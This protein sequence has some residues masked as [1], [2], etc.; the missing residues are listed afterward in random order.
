M[1]RKQFGT[2]NGTGVADGANSVLSGAGARGTRGDLTTAEEEALQVSHG[3]SLSATCWAADPIG[4]CA[5]PHIWRVLAF[6][7][8]SAPD[9]DLC[10]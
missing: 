2:A 8:C 5:L 6:A 9:C 7:V 3:R 1:L 10:L 4:S